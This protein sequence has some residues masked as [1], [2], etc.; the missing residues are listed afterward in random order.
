[1]PG[2]PMILASLK[3]VLILLSVILP[4]RIFAA[5]TC[6]GL[7]RL[8]RVV[9]G[10]NS[11]GVPLV[12]TIVRHFSL[13]ACVDCD[14]LRNERKNSFKKT[15]SLFLLFLKCMVHPIISF[16]FDIIWV[17]YPLATNLFEEI[18]HLFFLL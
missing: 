2:S 8:R 12:G 7:G 18:Q 9:I 10:K 4:P 11:K 5:L 14:L 17:T 13:F 3:A 1:M 16:S 6:D 15:I